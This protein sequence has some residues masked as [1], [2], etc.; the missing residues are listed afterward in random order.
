MGRGVSQ[1]RPRPLRRVGASQPSS[2]PPPAVPLR[3]AGGWGGLAVLRQRPPARPAAP[4]VPHPSPWQRPARPQA[5]APVSRCT[6]VPSRSPPQRLQ[7]CKR[8]CINLC[9]QRSSRLNPLFKQ[10]SPPSSPSSAGCPSPATRPV[11]ALRRGPAAGRAGWPL[12]GRSTG[13]GDAGGLRS[14]GGAF[15]TGLWQ[16]SV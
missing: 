4:L 2:G 7:R 15:P 14:P 1:I 10:Q 3:T 12:A 6:T 9:K 11:C 8:F 5:F 13:W 16:N